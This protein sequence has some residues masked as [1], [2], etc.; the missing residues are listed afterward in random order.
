MDGVCQTSLVSKDIVESRNR[1]LLY[2]T[3]PVFELWLK[4]RIF[5]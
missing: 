5:V 1:G 2:F 4:R 3:D